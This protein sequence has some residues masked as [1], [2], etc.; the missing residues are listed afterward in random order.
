MTASAVDAGQPREVHE[1]GL[2]A[3]LQL[4]ANRRRLWPTRRVIADLTPVLT[5]GSAHC[6]LP[7]AVEQA[8][9]WIAREALANALR[10]HAPGQGDVVLRLDLHEHGLRLEV[11][12]G[13]HDPCGLDALQ[14]A[15]PGAE[16]PLGLQALQARARSVGARLSVRW[17]QQGG[18]WTSLSWHRYPA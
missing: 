15:P 8:A 9:F 13:L 11:N 17:A 1:F 5:R 3:A 12:D 2:A 4:E 6:R 10:R 18:T 14:H 7:G 16:P